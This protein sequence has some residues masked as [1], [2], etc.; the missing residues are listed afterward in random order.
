M[1]FF[2]R[3]LIFLIPT[4]IQ[5]SKYLK[6]RDIFAKVGKNFYFCPRK[7]PVDPKLI[8]FGDNVSVATEVQFVNHDVIH[9]V[10]N[11]FF[12]KNIEKF[13][14]CIEIK[15]NVF[16]GSRTIIMPNVTIGPNVIIGSGTIITKSIEESGVYVGN[17]I[18]KIG[19]FN[20]LYKKRLEY[21]KK[22]MKL[23]KNELNNYLW[24]EFYE[25]QR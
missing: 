2:Q 5:R 12:E 14:G 19:E 6:N 3:I 24:K 18:K 16:I 8:K 4:G 22:I 21:T 23:N 13:Y 25:K 10:F 7:I 15:N 17:P 20:E 11:N 9:K 1:S